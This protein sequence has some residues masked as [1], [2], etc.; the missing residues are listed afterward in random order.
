MSDGQRIKVSERGP[1]LVRGGVPLKTEEPL[2]ASDG[3]PLT[4]RHDDG[5]EAGTSYA[6]CRCG[7]SGNKPFCDG[8]HAKIEWDSADNAPGNYDDNARDLGG[9]GV[10]IK[11]FRAICAHVGMCTGPATNV[12]KLAH[13]TADTEKRAEAIAMIENCPSG[14]LTYALDGLVNEPNLPAQIGVL[15]DGP[16]WVSGGIPVERS[17]GESLEERN[18]VTLCRCGGSAIKPLCDGTH[19]EVWGTAKAGE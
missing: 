12:W 15:P 7:G 11:D 19:K 16:L 6:L 13:Q 8:T 10:D 17:T 9:E 2:F 4:W 18:R 3:E 1:Y 5:P 14:A